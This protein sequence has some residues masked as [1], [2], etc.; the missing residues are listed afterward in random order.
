MRMVDIIHDKREGKALTDEQLQFVVD[1]VVDE[2]L[3]SYQISA[4]LMA[5]H[6][7]GMTAEET[8]KLTLMMAH[9]G[10]MMDLSSI[11]GIKVDKHSTGG[12][13]D[14]VSLPLAALVAALDIPVPM[15][16]GRG[17]GHTGGTL[18]KL[19]SIPGYQIEISTEDFLK[20]VA[21][22]KCAI[23]GPTGSF[24]PADKPIYALRDVTDTTDV[25]PLMVSSIM[26]KK[27]AAGADAI[28]IDVKTGAGAFMKTLEESTA[29][30]KALVQTANAAGMKAIAVISDMNQPL[31]N[32]VGNALEVEEAIDLLK[33]KAPKDITEITLTLASYMVVLGGKAKDEKEARKLLEGTIKDGS[34]L[35]RFRAMIEAQHGDG[36]VVDDYSLLPEAKY[37]IPLTAKASGVITKIAAD[38]V[39]IASMMLGGGRAM[40][41]DQLDYAV[42][43][44]LEKKVGD[45]V[46]E[47]DTILTLHANREEVEDVKQLLYDHIEISDRGETHPMIYDIIKE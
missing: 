26:S 20:Q 15:I 30:A 8:S 33:G 29:L 6:F 45:T 47:G 17:L 27:I 1:G 13:G 16:S 18:D 46:N 34:A 11:P 42:G 22:E 38:S 39:G 7:Q 5:I 14:K 43:I 3:P 35:E 28:V 10:D 23:I 24:A 2:S 21:E 37:K 9:S 44:E 40:T 32:K 25:M 4:L 31:G 41:D 19:E 12:V 36:H